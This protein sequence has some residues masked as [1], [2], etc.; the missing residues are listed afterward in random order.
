M[1]NNL[2]G[3]GDGYKLYRPKKMCTNGQKHDIINLEEVNKLFEGV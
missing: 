3:G 2:F 1:F